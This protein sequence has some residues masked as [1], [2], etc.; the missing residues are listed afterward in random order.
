MNS[1]RVDHFDKS[2]DYIH[3][4]LDDEEM[5][6]SCNCTSF[7]ASQVQNPDSKYLPE[8][9]P[10]LQEEVATHGMVRQTMKPSS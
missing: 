4:H 3:H 2:K 9:L 6:H 7:C 10:L 5:L 1:M 8:M